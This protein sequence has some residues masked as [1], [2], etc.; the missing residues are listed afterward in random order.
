MDPNLFRID[1]E[2]LYEEVIAIV[3]LSFFLE[4]ALALVFEHRLFVEKFSKKGFKEFIAFGVAFAV[5]KKW[6]FD[7]VSVMLTAETTNGMGHAITAGVVAGGSKAS[8]KFFHDVLKTYSSAEDER[9][10]SPSAE[11]KSGVRATEAAEE[12]AA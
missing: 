6:D 12:Q 1:G 11:R 4:R 3:V 2:R 8:V 7:A 5:C 10:K 9:R